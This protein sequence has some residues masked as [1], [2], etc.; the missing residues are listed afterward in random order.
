MQQLEEN[1]DEYK[2]Q[3]LHNM[4]EMFRYYEKLQKVEAENESYSSKIA[5]QEAR[6]QDEKD[7]YN[8]RINDLQKDIRE[9]ESEKNVLDVTIRKLTSH[10]N[11]LKIK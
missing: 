6:I 2:Q 7:L 9:K 11:D 4:I 3:N 5:V 8:Q 10:K 1:A